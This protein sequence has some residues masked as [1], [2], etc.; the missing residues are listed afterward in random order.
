MNAL[1]PNRRLGR[2]VGVV[3]AVEKRREGVVAQVTSNTFELGGGHR[4]GISVD[5]LVEGSDDLLLE[6]VS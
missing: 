5:E 4:E 2:R 3:N 1:F 6:I